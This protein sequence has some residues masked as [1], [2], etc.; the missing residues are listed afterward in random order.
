M[1]QDSYDLNLAW[2][3]INEGISSKVFP[4]AQVVIVKDD[5]LIAHESFGGFTY[6]EDSKEVNNNSIYDIAQLLRYYQL[7][8]LQ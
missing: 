2:D 7:L 5:N 6:F 1:K 8:Q 4:G 3:V